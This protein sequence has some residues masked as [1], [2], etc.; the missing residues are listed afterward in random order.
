MYYKVVW[1]EVTIKKTGVSDVTSV[2]PLHFICKNYGT[3]I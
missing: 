3:L 2:G 1:S